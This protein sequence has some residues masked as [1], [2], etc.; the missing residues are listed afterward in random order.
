MRWRVKYVGSSRGRIDGR[1]DA[2]GRIV[3][4]TDIAMVKM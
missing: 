3:V 1:E 2:E 4:V